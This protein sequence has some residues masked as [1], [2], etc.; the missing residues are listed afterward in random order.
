[1]FQMYYQCIHQRLYHLTPAEY[2]DFTAI[3]IHA[4][5]VI[6]IISLITGTGTA[7]VEYRRLRGQGYRF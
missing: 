6:F 2:E 5:K 7:T 4:R 1:M 3:I